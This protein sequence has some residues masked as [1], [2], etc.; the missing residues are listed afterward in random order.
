MRVDN[1]L[2]VSR[3]FFEK[4]LAAHQELES[5]IAIFL[6]EY[7]IRVIVQ[8]HVIDDFIFNAQRIRDF[9]KFAVH[10]VRTFF[11][12]AVCN[13]KHYHRRFFIGNPDEF[14]LKIASILIFVVHL[15]VALP[16]KPFTNALDR[17]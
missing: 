9:G 3:T 17:R 4:V 16:R 5:D 11:F 15:E 13:A 12:V 14:Q 2:D 10:H 1:L 6:V 8:V 7:V